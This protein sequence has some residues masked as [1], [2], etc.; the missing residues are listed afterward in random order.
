MT[1]RHRSIARPRQHSVD[2]VQTRLI[3]ATSDAARCTIRCECS[4]LIQTVSCRPQPGGELEKRLAASRTW[5]Y[6]QRSTVTT[7]KWPSTVVSIVNLVW[8]M[9][10]QF[11]AL[12]VDLY[13]AKLTIRWNDRRAVTK[14]RVWDTVPEESILISENTQISLTY[15]HMSK[16]LRLHAKI[17]RSVF[18]TAV[19]T[20]HRPVT[21]RQTDGRTDIWP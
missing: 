12:T 6:R 17:P 9:T 4:Q 18:R 19:L 8:P 11:I 13:P 7:I 10:V 3:C 2:R 20:Q 15:G 21:D 14:S 16:E 1:D 5:F